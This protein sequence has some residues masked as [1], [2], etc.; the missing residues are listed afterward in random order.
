MNMC[1]LCNGFSD[2]ASAASCPNCQTLMIDHGKMTDYLDEYSAYME[3]DTMKLFDGVR[4]SLEAHR[5]VHL[6][7]CMNCLHEEAREIQE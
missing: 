4:E 1:P 5:C 2:E 3:I 7:S 6:F